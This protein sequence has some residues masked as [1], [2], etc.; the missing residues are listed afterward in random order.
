MRQKS[1]YAESPSERL[2][3]TIRRVTRKRHSAEEKI[4]IVL[5]GLRGDPHLCVGRDYV[6]AR[7]I[8][9]QFGGNAG[10]CRHIISGHLSSGLGMFLARPQWGEGHV[11][12]VFQISGG[13]PAPSERGAWRRDGPYRRAFF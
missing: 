4:R 12:F 3:K 1:V 7:S 5:D 9:A 10:P 13:A 8:G 11:G 2:V 6:A